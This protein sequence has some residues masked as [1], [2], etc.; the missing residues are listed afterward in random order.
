MLLTLFSVGHLSRYLPTEHW[1][2]LPVTRMLV[3]QA[4]F[5]LAATVFDEPGRIAA[6]PPLVESDLGRLGNADVFVVFFESYGAIVFDENPYAEQLVGAFAAL[7]RSLAQAG[8]HAASARVV[9]STFGGASWLAHA[10]FLSGLKIADQ[11]D[12]Q[13]LL[14]SDRLTFID[15]FAAAGYRCIALMPGLKYTW[16]EGQFYPFDYVYDAMRLNYRGPSY[17]WWT[18]PDQFS[19]YRVHRDE[20]ARSPR[21][22]LLVFFPTITSHIP[23]APVPPY[24]PDWTQ[25]DTDTPALA[26]AEQLALNQ[27]LDGAELRSAYVQSIRYNLHVLEG[28]LNQY[29]PPHAL[30]LIL[31]DHQPPAL[32]SGHPTSW[33]V[34]VHVLSRDATLIDAF[35]AVGFQQGLVPEEQVLG[36]IETLSPLLLRVLDSH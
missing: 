16:P 14:I 3:E 22:P 1:F 8:W 17:G 4:R 24:Y 10:S 5:V 26:E 11:S 25:I 31:G 20:V 30:F 7:Q 13:H 35:L 18:I 36:G 9:S 32:I 21:K 29:A 12:Y 23:F 33:Q 19:L 34:P 6:Q 27:R 28:Y 2:A 15:R